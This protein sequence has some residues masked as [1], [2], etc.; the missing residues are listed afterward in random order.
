MSPPTSPRSLLK[1]STFLYNL[2]EDLIAPH[3]AE[4]RGKSRFLNNK[5][6]HSEVRHGGYGVGDSKETES[7]SPLTT[8]PPPP[9]SLSQ[10]DEAFRSLWNSSLKSNTHVVF[11]DSR[12]VKARCSADGGVEVLFLDPYGTTKGMGVLGEDA[13]GQSW[14]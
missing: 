10:F 6:I 14:R 4:V 8:L 3:P 13:E 7:V 12:V 2:P 5:V 9:S 1:S 11:N